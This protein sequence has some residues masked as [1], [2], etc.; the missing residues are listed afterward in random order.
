MPLRPE[1]KERLRRYVDFLEKE[2]AEFAR[3]KQID[4]KEYSEKRD[5]RRNLERWIE[6][7]VN[8]SIDIAKVLL[9]AEDRDIPPTYKEVLKTLG[10][11][12]YFDE[13]FGDGVAGWA[14]LRNI[15]THEYL[16]MSWT[17]IKKFLETA[18]PALHRFIDTLKK[19]L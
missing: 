14:V 4:W 19:Q 3:F 15:I 8:C 9:V 7:I 2:T 18:E 12:P 11:L 17:R 10:S 6:N 5:T 13:T 16:D 1:D